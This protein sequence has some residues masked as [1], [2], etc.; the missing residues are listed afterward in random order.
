VNKTQ[1]T[2]DRD[3]IIVGEDENGWAIKKYGPA[4]YYVT[5]RVRVP[6]R[7]WEVLWSWRYA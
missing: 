3:T 2:W 1:L 5:V 7:L 4:R 6:R